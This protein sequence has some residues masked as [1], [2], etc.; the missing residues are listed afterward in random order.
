MN[1]PSALRPDL[2]FY[3]PATS[4][5]PERR[6][7]TLKHG[8]TFALLDH[9]GNIG[10]GA[11][12]PEGLYHAD[13][14]HMA[15]WRL[16]IDRN[17]P[18]LLG[19]AIRDDNAALHADLTNPDVFED[20]RL[21][22][23]K[24]TIQVTRNLFLF[25]GAAH[26]R[27]AVRNFGDSPQLIEIAL[28][29]ACDFADLFEVRGHPRKHERNIRSETDE[30]AVRFLYAGLDGVER[31]TL[32]RFAPA[33][34][35]ITADAA[36]FHLQLASGERAS[37][38]IEVAFAA[39]VIEQWDSSRYFRRFRAARRALKTAAAR[40]A[41][42]ET[43]NEVVNEVLCRSTADLHMLMTYTA[44]G[45]YP[46]AGVPWFS[47]VFGRDG[48]LTAMEL[49][50]LDPGVAA[51]VLRFLAAN[52]AAEFDPVA[53]A[54]PGKVL[55]E[56]RKGELA[57]I[58]EVPFARYYGSIDSTPLFVMLAG[59][60]ERRTSDLATIRELWPN[61]QA[62]LQWIERWGDRDGDGFVEY[63]RENPR[64]LVNQGWKDSADSVFH[65]DSHLAEGPI[66]LVEVQAYVYGAW[67]EATRLAR[68]LG[69]TERSTATSAGWRCSPQMPATP[70]SP[71]SPAATGPGASHPAS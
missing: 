40:I 2:Q 35:H 46:Y 18:L 53:D 24:D 51:G 49:L 37:L 48:L 70:C 14:R 8:D 34:G 47:T 10:G 58:K 52:Q 11:G 55:H 17:R 38:F 67:R 3:I 63:Q 16:S 33:P 23:Q 31:R 22:R 50:W 54:E 32:I 13:T 9:Y 7:R 57:L 26:E 56:I 27:I 62:A 65:T 60:Y 4:S 25:S 29:F 28:E 21:I 61:L 1:E 68:R 42:I 36:R 45:P 20:G 44:Q 15:L 30:A 43:S 66:A 12:N 19:S 59:M 5:L 71:A 69:E 39:A 6:P 41:T 64:G